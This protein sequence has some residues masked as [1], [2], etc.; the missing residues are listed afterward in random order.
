MD[1]IIGY[2]IFNGVYFLIAA[3]CYKALLDSR[4]EFSR[5]SFFEAF[6]WGWAFFQLVFIGGVLYY[7]K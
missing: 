5:E 2:L 6:G 3:R 7:A 1:V 4:E